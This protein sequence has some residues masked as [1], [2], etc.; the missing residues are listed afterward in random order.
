MH[1]QSIP[2]PE[3]SGLIGEW[4]S[5]VEKPTLNPQGVAVGARGAGQ[6][7][8][9]T[10]ELRG[11]LEHLLRSIM[12]A[13]I[14]EHESADEHLNRAAA[15]LGIDLSVTRSV[16]MARATPLLGHA[17]VRGGLAPW[18]ILRVRIH[19]ESKLG[20]DPLQTKHLAALI[21]LNPF[22]FCRVF[23]RSFGESPHGFVM[24]RRIERA[25][26]LM[27]KGDGALSRIAAECGFADQAHFNRVF[28]KRTGESPGTWRRARSAGHT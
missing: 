14:D 4:R 5:L 21:G 8:S 9:D 6:R 17:L 18:Q 27:L 11:A 12:S 7:E 25:Q 24:R 19:I 10:S 3:V 28:R 16:P 1:T 26:G 23:R 2:S 20:T 13:Q 15:L 22:H